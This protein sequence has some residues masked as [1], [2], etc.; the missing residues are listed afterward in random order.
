[1]Q[2]GDLVKEMLAVLQFGPATSAEICAEIG[3]HKDVVGATLSRLNKPGITTPKRIYIERYV[4]D[5]VGQRRY[6]RAQ[7][8]LGDHEDAR[9]PKSS[10]ALNSRRHRESRNCMI[11]SVFD[12]GTKNSLRRSL[13]V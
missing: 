2:R 9:K 1:M 11:T 8:A 3:K 5:H 4:Y 12:L 7:Y 6:P 13:N 10:A